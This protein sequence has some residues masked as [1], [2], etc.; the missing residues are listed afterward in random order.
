MQNDTVSIALIFSACSVLISF[1]TFNRSGKRDVQ[2]DT[3]DLVEVKSQLQYISRGIDDI[4][5]NDRVR[6]EQIKSLNE[7][8]LVAKN[9]IKNI[10]KKLDHLENN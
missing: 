2:N 3:K 4:K 6:D 1:L 10:Y 8:I 7:D 9:D 5:I